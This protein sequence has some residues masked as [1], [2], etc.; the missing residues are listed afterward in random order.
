ME[1]L[2]AWS[3]TGSIASDGSTTID[4][5]TNF[6]SVTFTTNIGIKILSCLPAIINSVTIKMFSCQHF[7]ASITRSF[8]V[9]PFTM[10]NSLMFAAWHHFKICQS[11][12]KAIPIFMMDNAALWNRTVGLFPKPSV[13][14]DQLLVSIK[15]PISFL[16]RA[17]S[18][19]TFIGGASVTVP[20]TI[21][22]SAPSSFLN[23][24]VAVLDGTNCHRAN[25][26]NSVPL[27]QMEI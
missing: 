18:I 24:F 13:L 8:A 4:T 15:P 26:T 3:A 22:H 20:T 27:S 17:S 2:K 10:V 14:K 12:I 25:Y 16:N 9:D 23:Y 1:I 21:V 5:I 7:F 6:R 19:G 11:I